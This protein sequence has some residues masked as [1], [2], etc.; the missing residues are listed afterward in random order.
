[1]VIPV[2]AVAVLVVMSLFFLHRK[3]SIALPLAAKSGM[4][5]GAQGEGALATYSSEG[6]SSKIGSAHLQT[7]TTHLTGGSAGAAADAPGFGGDSPQA[8]HEAYVDARTAELR[9]LSMDNDSASL[10][11]ILSELSNRDPEIREAARE[12]A[13]QFGSR[14]AIPN[15]AE[16]AQQT[17]DATEKAALTEAIEFLKLPSITEDRPA[18]TAGQAQK[19]TK[20]VRRNN[21]VKTPG[22]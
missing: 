9:D 20:T 14:D 16:A 1:M 13:V 4:D 22:H 6:T 18:Q 17:D 2:L 10:E 12:A 15:L 8:A 3:H 7:P 19:A 11:I 21:G 5:R